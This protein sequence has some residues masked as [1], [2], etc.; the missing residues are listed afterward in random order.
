MASV[1]SQLEPGERVL[2]QTGLHPL[3]FSGAATL[4][5]F[6]TLIVALLIRHNDLPAQTELQIALVGAAVAVLGALPSALRW[7]NTALAVTDRRVLMN[8]GGLRRRHLTVPLGPA[9]VE[10]ESGLTGSLFDH[11]TVTI[12]GPDGRSSSV[13]HVA[14]ARELVEVARA[15]AR[16]APRRSAG[17]S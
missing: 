8:G 10:Q 6:V 5:V 11:G 14:R 12:S 9:A 2:F 4:A 7:R 17:P 16:R 13:G 15:Q 3:A 1:E